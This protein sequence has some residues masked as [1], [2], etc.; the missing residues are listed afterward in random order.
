MR[1]LTNRDYDKLV[2]RID[3]LES[4]VWD[5][6]H[7]T[8]Y[9]NHVDVFSTFFAA[10]YGQPTTYKHNDLFR[11]ILDHLKLRPKTSHAKTELVPVEQPKKGKK[12]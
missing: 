8:E 11:M 7:D 4:Q 3:A 9:R 12:K 5:L 10:A 6:K 2:R 1:L